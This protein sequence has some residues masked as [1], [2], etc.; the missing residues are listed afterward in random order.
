MRTLGVLSSDSGGTTGVRTRL[1]NQMKRLFNA[2]IQ[3]IYEDKHGEATVN[4]LIADRTELWWTLHRPAQAGLWESKIL[5]SEPL[6]LN[7]IIHHPVPL[8]MK[9]P[10][11]AQTLLPGPGSLLVAHLSHL[12]THAPGA[13]YLAAVVPPVRN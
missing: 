11:G 13:D 3:L 6:S 9:H 12:R 2:H 1:R 4:A 7:E 5:L 8:D 10:Q